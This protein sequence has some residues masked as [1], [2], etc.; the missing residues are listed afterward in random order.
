[1]KEIKNILIISI[2][3][4]LAVFSAVY[5]K[6]LIEL[7]SATNNNQGPVENY[8]NNNQD[9]EVKD[10]EN[11]LAINEDVKGADTTVV[12][13]PKV[14]QLKPKPKPKPVVPKPVPTTACIVTISGS[15]YDLTAYKR[16]H[17]GG[18]VFRCGTDMTAAFN[19]QH[20]PNYL[21]MI[22]KYKIK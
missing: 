10:V 7:K 17:P 14:V 21:T 18:N 4:F 3:V 19:N 16:M 22:A 9:I 6:H 8:I 11:E 5:L 1:M 2:V 13:P 12:T 15:R 20:N